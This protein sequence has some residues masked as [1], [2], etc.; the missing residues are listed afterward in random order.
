MENQGILSQIRELIGN[1]Q[2]ATEE[3]AEG[4][5]PGSV[6]KAR[7]QL[8]RRA[9]ASVSAGGSTQP[10]SSDPIAQVIAL[11]GEIAGLE[12]DK[13][14]LYRERDFVELMLATEGEDRQRE[15]S[16]LSAQLEQKQ[17]KVKALEAELER[18]R[19]LE[20][21][22]GHPCAICHQPL[23]G[24]VELAVAREITKRLAHQACIDH[25]REK[26]LVFEFLNRELPAS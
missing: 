19:P 21:W 26:P 25:Q 7:R 2:T 12:E 3:I 24:I 23:A 1:G 13:A 9:T 16:A 22:A 8:L 5:A 17:V 4:F 15:V 6:Y 14:R 11:R 18:L 20:A 10:P